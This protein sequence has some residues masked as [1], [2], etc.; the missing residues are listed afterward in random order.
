MLRLTHLACSLRLSPEVATTSYLP[1]IPEP[2]EGLDLC[3]VMLLLC[4]VKIGT[5]IQ[6]WLLEPEP[7]PRHSAG[8]EETPKISTPSTYHHQQPDTKAT[9]D[10][11]LT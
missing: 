3:K 11:Y 7:F 8:A 5:L 10:T 4:S 1:S 9:L 6:V 2:R